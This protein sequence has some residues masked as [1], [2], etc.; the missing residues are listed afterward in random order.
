MSNDHPKCSLKILEGQ[1]KSIS[2]TKIL[3]FKTLKCYEYRK[4]SNCYNICRYDSQNHFSHT[5]CYYYNCYLKLILY[6]TV[7][8]LLLYK[9]LRS[10]ESSRLF[11]LGGR[12]IKGTARPENRNT[13]TP[14]IISYD[15]R[16]KFQ[17][18]RNIKSLIRFEKDLFYRKNSSYYF[19]WQSNSPSVAYRDS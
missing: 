1:T 6:S 10:T 19:L 12:V 2:P 8:I 5:Y 7:K 17:E 4:Y 14:E 9:R 11:L 3:H 13:V 15:Y 18:S 16:I